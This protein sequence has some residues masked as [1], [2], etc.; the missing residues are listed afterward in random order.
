[1]SEKRAVERRAR[2]VLAR[3]RMPEP[4]SIDALI[5]EVSAVMG[6]EIQVQTVPPEALE[7]SPCGMTLVCP[8]QAVLVVAEGSPR[9]HTE[10]VICHELAHMLLE[11]QSGEKPPR[12]LLQAWFP[13]FDPDD[14]QMM[15]GRTTFDTREE[16][17]AELLATLIVDQG[18]A[19][20]SARM[21]GTFLG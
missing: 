4:W 14:V 18:T 19:K 6:F 17:E 11:H 3:L 10:L 13:S 12:E 15:F 7:D 20:K 2:E 16:Q 1:M 9:W 8:G 5:G 21:L